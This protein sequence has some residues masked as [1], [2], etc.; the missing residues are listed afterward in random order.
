MKRIV[1]LML[2][3]WIPLFINKKNYKIVVF[4]LNGSRFSS[5]SSI[6]FEYMIKNTSLDV[7]YII[8]NDKLRK[9]LEEKC[10][11]H[12]IELKSV[13]DI[14]FIS[15]AGTWITDGGFALKTPFG[16]K[17]RVLINLWH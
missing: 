16:H 14:I 8:N 17:N 5:N 12:F 7:R 1:L 9:E 6:L 4:V 10:G 13:N 2:S 15:K 3:F 11:N